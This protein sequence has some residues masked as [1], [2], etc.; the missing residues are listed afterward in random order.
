MGFLTNLAL[1]IWLSLI[2]FEKTG[3][4]EKYN[5]LQK[6]LVSKDSAIGFSPLDL[7]ECHARFW[8]IHVLGPAK[9]KQFEQEPRNYHLVP[10]DY[11]LKR[12]KDAPWTGYT[13]DVFDATMTG[14][15]YGEPYRRALEQWGSTVAVVMFPMASYFALQT[16]NPIKAY[17]KIEDMVRAKVSIRGQINIHEQ[18]RKYFGEMKEACNRIALEET[19][20]YL[21]PG[22]DVFDRSKLIGL[23]E[24]QNRSYCLYNQWC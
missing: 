5:D 9:V 6:K 10:A 11:S 16:P 20:S 15:S 24:N 13:G 12:P 7:M 22:W 2:Y 23:G 1:E 18:W 19:G 3:E 8:D 17:K 4:T 21:V 14:A